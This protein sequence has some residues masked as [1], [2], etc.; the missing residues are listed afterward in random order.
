M[1][2]WRRRRL[3][4]ICW[5]RRSSARNLRGR[6]GGERRRRE[7]P[8][9]GEA[10]RRRAGGGGGGALEAS[11]LAD[12]GGA[13]HREGEAL[14]HAVEDLELLE[15]DLSRRMGSGAVRRGEGG[16]RAGAVRINS[17]RVSSPVSPRLCPWGSCRS[18]S[19]ARGRCRGRRGRTR[20]GPGQRLRTQGRPARTPPVRA[21]ARQ[22]PPERGPEAASAMWLR[23]VRVPAGG[24]RAWTIPEWSRMSTKMSPPRSLCLSTQ[25]QRVTRFPMCSS[26]RDPQ[27]VSRSGQFIRSLTS[28]GCLLAS[29]GVALGLAAAVACV[30]NARRWILAAARC[31]CA[32]GA[33][34][35]HANGRAARGT[36][37]RA[38]DP[39]PHRRACDDAI[40]E[41]VSAVLAN[42]ALLGMRHHSPHSRARRIRPQPLCGRINNARRQK[43]KR[44]RVPPTS[45]VG[46]LLGCTHRQC[47]PCQAR[48][49]ARLYRSH[50]KNPLDRACWRTYE[51]TRAGLQL[52]THRRKVVTSAK[53]SAHA[54]LGSKSL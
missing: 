26:R 6:G 13:G 46:V 23:R 19:C 10:G 37:C 47:P 40:L 38:I 39:A 51:R 44:S 20:G 34:G 50:F 30:T 28:V 43:R 4:V 53:L 48:R 52:F 45:A 21:W 32:R 11:L 16:D 31:T 36:A 41:G 1:T 5:R 8:G 54:F 42:V 7:G 49:R 14:A 35:A 27:S 22:Q 33:T 9:G 25:P 29:A 15:G 2:L 17:S 3:P 24:G 18:S 12:V